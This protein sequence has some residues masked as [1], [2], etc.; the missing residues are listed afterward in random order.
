M[1]PPKV[2]GT[3]APRPYR[4][5]SSPRRNVFV[6]AS[7]CKPSTAE[8]CAGSIT[9]TTSA[10]FNSSGESGRL[11]NASRSSPFSRA[12][13]SEPDDATPPASAN[14]PADDTSNPFVSASACRAIASASGLRHVFPEQTKRTRKGMVSS[15]SQ[16][17]F[18]CG[19]DV[20]HP[21]DL[22]AAP[23]TVHDRRR[24]RAGRAAAV[25]SEV[26]AGPE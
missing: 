22:A 21:Q 1:G 3:E 16:Q 20:A 17:L 19:Q 7:G 14:V 10:E 4:P 25:E 12:T 9:T 24:Q 6:S 5:Y 15:A 2:S 23:A 8:R 11:W 26:D 18:G 13:S